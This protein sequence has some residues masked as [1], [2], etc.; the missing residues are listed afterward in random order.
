M[1]EAYCCVLQSTS[2]QGDFVTQTVLMSV[3]LTVSLSDSLLTGVV[4]RGFVRG[5]ATGCEV[6]N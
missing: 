6:C 3:S 4:R 2:V 1:A 5:V